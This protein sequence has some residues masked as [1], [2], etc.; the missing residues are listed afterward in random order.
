MEVII[1]SSCGLKTPM[2]NFVVQILSI[3]ELDCTHNSSTRRKVVM[4]FPNWGH[5]GDWRN[6]EASSTILKSMSQ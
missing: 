5:N 4:S 3:Y 1:V 6:I 2:E